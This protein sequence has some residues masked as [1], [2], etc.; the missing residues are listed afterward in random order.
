LQ[1]ITPR[2]SAEIPDDWFYKSSLTLLAPDGQS[3]VIVSS[4]PLDPETT[5]ERYVEVQGTLLQGG[6]FPGY[7]ERSL[8]PKDDAFG[9]RRGFLRHFEW[10]PPDNVRV[11]QIQVYCV[12]RGRGHTA[13]ATTPKEGFDE[14]ELMLRDILDGLRI[15]EAHAPHGVAPAPSELPT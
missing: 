4:E 15:E 14:R 10:Q 1:Q 5:L 13:T 11:T 2:H 3:N 12:D 9:D 7:Q 6:E 8:E